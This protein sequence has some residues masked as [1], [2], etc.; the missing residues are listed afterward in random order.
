MK[1]PFI[2]FGKKLVIF[3]A[4]LFVV[5]RALGKVLS[6]YFLKVNSSEAARINYAVNEADEDIVIF[7]SSR[8]NHHYVPSVFENCTHLSCYNAGI[9]GEC[10]LYH[11]CVL[12]CMLK[13]DAPKIVVLDINTDEFSTWRNEEVYSKLS[14]LLP[15]YYS[16]KEIQPIVDLK[17][18]Y[19]KYKVFSDAYRYNS[20]AFTIAVNNVL[21]KK[22][23][24]IHGYCPLYRKLSGPPDQFDM[25]HGQSLDSVKVEIFKTFIR[26]TQAAGCKL[27][28]C[29]S[30][31]YQKRNG[32]T[33]TI[34]MAQKL[35]N[36]RHVPFYDFSQDPFFQV[37]P[38]YFFDA[39]HLNDD[40]AKLYSKLV[41]DK[42]KNI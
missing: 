40:G 20:M 39:S 34:S 11:D 6:H 13:R 30:P 21:N 33:K 27:L 35:C 37:H 16:H 7:G 25:S 36:E 15:Y 22:D 8:A 29:I 4:I 1:S 23:T 32:V 26:E 42:I 28:V 14:A 19:E 3:L 10:I 17:S 9:D 18:Q 12:K 38:E 2:Q 41:C 24:S 5:D 31:S